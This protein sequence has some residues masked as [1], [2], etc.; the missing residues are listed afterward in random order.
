M[1]LFVCFSLVLVIST[2]ENN[3]EGLRVTIGNLP[4]SLSP[5]S[6]TLTSGDRKGQHL[7]CALGNEQSKVDSVFCLLQGTGLGQRVAI[8]VRF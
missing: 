7:K 4:D 1:R 3:S 5:G 6:R 2:Q 8:G